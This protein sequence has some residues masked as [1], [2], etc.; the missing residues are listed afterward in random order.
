MPVSALSSAC[1]HHTVSPGL[2]WVGSRTT[3]RDHSAP[4]SLEN[5]LG[6]TPRELINLTALIV[7]PVTQLSGGW[8]G[9]IS[10]LLWWPY[11]PTT[12]TTQLQRTWLVSTT[13]HSYKSGEG[14]LQ[15][16]FRII[17]N[18]LRFFLILELCR[19]VHHTGGG[20]I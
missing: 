19:F 15:T 17:F 5:S 3:F 14:I 2:G 11:S 7:S 1:R 6:I 18:A 4:L 20:F 8:R 9:L 12:L 13:G 10:G 16:T